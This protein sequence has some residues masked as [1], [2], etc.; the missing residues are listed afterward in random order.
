M[1]IEKL[2]KNLTKNK[3]IR[4]IA[5]AIL[6]FDISLIIFYLVSVF[7]TKNIFIILFGVFYILREL[8]NFKLR[9]EIKKNLLK[10]EENGYEAWL[11]NLKN[12][13]KKW[14]VE[15]DY[16]NRKKMDMRMAQSI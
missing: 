1:K 12:M 14:D 16:L 4:K 11:K 9:N 5:L 2:A 10:Q 3:N 6:P 8:I 13:A 15:E 7:T